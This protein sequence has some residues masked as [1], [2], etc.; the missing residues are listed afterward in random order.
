MRKH[1]R[2]W[3]V[4]GMLLAVYAAI[5]GVRT[6]SAGGFG[7]AGL[8]AFLTTFATGVTG[9]GLVIGAVGLAGYVGSLVRCESAL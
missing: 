9:L 4:A 5:F 6:A 3:I 7:I 1:L 2:K 8:D